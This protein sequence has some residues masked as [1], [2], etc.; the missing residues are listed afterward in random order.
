MPIQGHK[1]ARTGGDGTLETFCDT[2][3]ATAE[4]CQYSGTEGDVEHSHKNI[5]V[6]QPLKGFY[7]V[8]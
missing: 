3:A 2:P 5:K 8:K 1:R 7:I 6:D 4:P